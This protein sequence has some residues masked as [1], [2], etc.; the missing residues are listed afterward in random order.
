[1]RPNIA[2]IESKILN[3]RGHKVMIDSDLA[4]LYEVETKYLNRQVRRNTGRFPA[5]FMFRLSKQEKAEL[6]TNWH[7]FK[8]LKHSYS[9]PHVFTEHGVAMLSTIL[10]SREATK[11]SIHI[12]KTFIRLKECL[13]NQEKLFHKLIKLQEKVGK[14]DEEIEKL[15]EA[16]HELMKIPEKP[17]REIGFHTRA[18]KKV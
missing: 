8:N 1:M 16:I 14:H 18:E 10:K 15:F 7:Q 2:P 13:S 5:E 17:K 9:L 12:I 11:I 6:V 4:R 3:L